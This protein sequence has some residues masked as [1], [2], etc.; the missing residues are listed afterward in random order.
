MDNN[1]YKSKAR[2]YTDVICKQPGWDDDT[3]IGDIAI[4]LKDDDTARRIDQQLEQPFYNQNKINFFRLN[5]SGYNVLM[6][7]TPKAVKLYMVLAQ[8]MNQS[9]VICISKPDLADI[10]GMSKPTIRNAI[11][12]L[13]SSGLLIAERGDEGQGE[14]TTYILNPEVIASGK[15][16]FQERL[17]LS[18][19][20]R[21]S[22]KKPN[23]KNKF[24]AICKLVKDKFNKLY[25]VKDAKLRG[26]VISQAEVSR[27][28]KKLNQQKGASAGNTDPAELAHSSSTHN[29]SNREH[30]KNQDTDNTNMLNEA[31]LTPEEN[32]LFDKETE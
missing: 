21:A 32:A 2:H 12:E 3:P 28:D 29:D 31:I 16:Q 8:N 13:E 15:I 6:T 25:E 18:Y 20:K 30:G 11:T 24:D 7:C 14:S 4:A 9:N 5:K 27:K 23:I 1:K 22:E 10:S 19:W 17:S 26:A